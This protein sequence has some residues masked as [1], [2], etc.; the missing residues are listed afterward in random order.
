MDKGEQYNQAFH[1][2][3]EAQ[4]R[5]DYFV[6]GVT[7]GILAFS[8][9]LGSNPVFSLR[10]IRVIS[11][12]SFLIS[13]ISGL[14]RLESVVQCRSLDVHVAKIV[15]SELPSSLKQ[16]REKWSKGAILSY[17]FQKWLLLTGLF[18]YAIVHNISFLSLS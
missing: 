9:Q 18:A 5:Y 8:I 14:R 1:R 16:E 2:H 6:L 10:W 12:L 13:F 17:N 15:P 7:P 3:H 4:T 11:W